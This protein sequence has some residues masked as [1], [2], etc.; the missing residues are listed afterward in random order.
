MA[1]I[2]FYFFFYIIFAISLKKLNLKT[3]YNLSYFSEIHIVVKGS[4]ERKLLY[5]NFD[6]EPFEV[7][8]ND[9][10]DDSCKKTCNLPEEINNVT[11]RFNREINSCYRMFYSLINLIE[12]DLSNFDFSKVTSMNSMFGHCKNL[13]KINFG[14]MKTSSL[15][16]MEFVFT[17]CY[18]LTSIDLSNFDTSK[19]KSMYGLFNGCNNL[20]KVN[21]GKINRKYEIII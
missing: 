17:H 4:G 16:N 15:L 2:I 5:D 10:K 3:I 1:K 7:L 8:V 9:I 21:L 20:E 18:K 11:L 6:I 19:V 12:M 13:S 14:K